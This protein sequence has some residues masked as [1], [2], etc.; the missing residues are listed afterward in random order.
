LLS[1]T[2]GSSI[3]LGEP[4]VV[5]QLDVLE[6]FLSFISGNEWYSVSSSDFI[7]LFNFKSE[8]RLSLFFISISY[9]ETLRKAI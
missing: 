9:K 2:C 1:N 4:V 7:P 3:L 8:L 5:L 6:L